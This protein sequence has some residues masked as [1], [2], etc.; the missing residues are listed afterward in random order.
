M[1]QPVIK[2]TLSRRQATILREALGEILPE[3]QRSESKKFASELIE[4]LTFEGESLVTTWHRADWGDLA[5]LLACRWK[6]KRRT[7]AADLDTGFRRLGN[8]GNEFRS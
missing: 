6:F 1:E 4:R 7:L 3:L 8:K 5:Y 2:R